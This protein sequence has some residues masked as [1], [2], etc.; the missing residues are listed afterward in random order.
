M[1]R[2]GAA[3]ILALLLGGC[4]AAPP[5]PPFITKPYEP[6]SRAE[7]IAVAWREWRL[8]GGRLDEAR[9]QAD[10]KPE[11]APGLWQRVGEY[12]W[13]GLGGRLPEAA[14][15]GKHDSE[16]RIFAASRDGQ[17][18]W[19]AAFISYV[20]R[21][22]GAGRLFPYAADHASYVDAAAA[23]RA[24]G[25]VAERPERYPPVPGD[26]ICHGRDW[27]DGLRFA[28]L[29]Q[30]RHWP[31]HC[32]LVVETA[33][34]SVSAISGNVEDAVALTRV[35]ATAAGMLMAPDGT[36]IDSRYPWFVVLR[37]LYAVPSAAATRP[38]Q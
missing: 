9:P 21:L 6:F 26:L 20:M 4:A 23:G 7:A 13:I 8:W 14:W 18:A 34:G 36:I 25:L 27:A 22:A 38:I 32:A 35:P 5:L 3:L 2:A 15:T 24:A 28:D 31:G 10:D 16:G 1:K 11:R 12:W 33:P 37:V 17:F 29:P 30:P 19:S